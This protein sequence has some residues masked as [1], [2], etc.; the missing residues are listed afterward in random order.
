MV[1][2]QRFGILD[3]QGVFWPECQANISNEDPDGVNHWSGWPHH[4][5]DDELGDMRN[6]ER[7]TGYGDGKLRGRKEEGVKGRMWKQRSTKL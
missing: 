1:T 3:V 2:F 5:A 7:E 6:E 4:G